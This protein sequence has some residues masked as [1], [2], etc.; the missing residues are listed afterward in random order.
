MHE[1]AGRLLVGTYGPSGRIV[2]KSRLRGGYKTQG[3]SNFGAG[4]C[5][6]CDSLAA[7]TQENGSHF[8]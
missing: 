3:D 2:M 8:G 7:L 5:M 4:S 1:R 6:A